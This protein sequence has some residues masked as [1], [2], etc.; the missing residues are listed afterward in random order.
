MGNRGSQSERGSTKH[1]STKELR[2]GRHSLCCLENGKVG[3]S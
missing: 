2:G 1:P 3:I